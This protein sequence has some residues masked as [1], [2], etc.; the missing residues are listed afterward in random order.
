MSQA[1]DAETLLGKKPPRKYMERDSSLSKKK[2][3][4]GQKPRS[5]KTIRN[6]L[7][8]VDLEEDEGNDG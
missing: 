3:E 2:A 5:E 7:Y 6:T 4:E 1:D 8:G